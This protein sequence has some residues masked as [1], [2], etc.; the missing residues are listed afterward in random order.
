[1]SGFKVGSTIKA[2]TKGLWVW[3]R[4]I[5]LQNNRSLLVID[6]EG[7]GSVEKDRTNNI[8]MKLFTLSVLLS[9]TI[10]YNTKHAISEDKIEEL[11]NV[12]NLTKRINISKD[13]KNNLGLDFSDFFP[14]LI[15]VL[16]DF[17]LDRG[18]LSS[19]EYLEQCLRSV[20]VDAIEGG[21]SKNICRDIITRNF[22]RRDCYTLVMPSTDELKLRNLDNEPLS[23]LRK[24]FIQ[25]VETMISSIKSTILPKKVSNVELDGEAL[26]GLLQAYVEDIN[27]E[28]NPVILSAL[29][30]V[31]L[32]KA[33]NISENVYEKFRDFITSKLD[34]QYPI[35]H[36]EIYTL[37]FESQNGLIAD[38]CKEINDTISSEQIGAY[39]LKLFSRMKDELELILE[40]NTTKYD[41]LIEQSTSLIS[42][43]IQYKPFTK[44]E[45]AKIYFLNFSNEIQNALTKYD[46]LPISD[47]SK[48]IVHSITNVLQSSLFE[49]LKKV[50]SNIEDLH[51]QLSSKLS[52]QI[53]DLNIKIRQLTDCLSQEKKITEL[54]EKEISETKVRLY[55]LES[56]NDSLK[57]KNKEKEKEYMNNINTEL[58]KY[59][60]M[61]NSYMNLMQEKDEKIALLQAQM[62]QLSNKSSKK[63]QE[64]SKENIKL[65]F[66]LKKM[67]EYSD[68]AKSPSRDNHHND[69]KVT[70]IQALFK[71]FQENI[72]TFKDD[73]SRFEQEKEN[74]FKEKYIQKC[75][76][77]IESKTKNWGEEISNLI[78]KQIAQIS[79]S[80]EMN[81]KRLQDENDSLMKE[82]DI[83]REENL[84]LSKYKISYEGS[85]QEIKELMQISF[86][87]DDIIAIQK[88]DNKLKDEQINELKLQKENLEIKLSEYITK[89][90]IKEE[91]FEEVFLT[92]EGV[93]EKKKSKYEAHFVNLSQETQ[94]RFTQYSK[95]YKFKI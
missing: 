20:N 7:L 60:K 39:I 11:S 29:E 83:I 75:K 58:Q 1:M 51:G 79:S 85:K 38:F 59:Q 95:K 16:R 43:S 50:G 91:E 64:L 48:H 76:E 15:W 87:K 63:S 12:A 78:K 23:S 86:G 81:M 41:E 2:C 14:E 31:L 24:E 77:E 94:E 37:F 28:E 44:L 57:R 40:A 52:S 30:N 26:F 34:G 92:I 93:F 61:E 46:D 35:N 27:N 55:E 90:R 68:R 82:L 9:S 70:N 33:K 13:N 18:S 89:Y 21:E 36:D 72:I 80:Y 88:R 22:K 8:D 4:P 49:K 47:I 65:Q 74:M 62:A 69:N 54:K 71:N 17:S 56:K 10:I 66:E 67:K 6:C 42:S 5:P 73:L 19:K 84:N 32:S 45:E 53:D 3:G 25:Q